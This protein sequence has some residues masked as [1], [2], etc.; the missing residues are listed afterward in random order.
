MD[1]GFS[2]TDVEIFK[3]LEE[4]NKLM[5][6]DQIYG[7]INLVGGAVMCLVFKARK[8]T[9]DIDAIFEPKTQI[10]DYIKIIA[11]DNNLPD[12]WLNDGVKGFLSTTAA[13]KDFKTFSNLNVKV[14][15]PEYMLA[16][17]CLAARVDSEN[18]VNDIK[19]LI[20]KL[21]LKSFDEVMQVIGKFYPADKFM[22]KT[23]Y[24]IKEILEDV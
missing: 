5:K 21:N 19:F 3:Y 13:F 4:L 12:N 22:I 18:E 17:K 2:M 10:N 14:A 24:L 11:N 6:K 1:S 15:T 16:M 8:V 7:D 20:N 9:R 23:E